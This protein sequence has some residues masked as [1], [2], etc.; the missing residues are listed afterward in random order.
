MA[1]A[2][3]TIGDGGR[4]FEADATQHAATLTTPGGIVSNRGTDANGSGK[5]FINP[6]GGDVDTSQPATVPCIPLP[7][8]S[9]YRLPFTCK[10]FTFKASASTFLV[11]SKG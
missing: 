7:V 9:S 1:S 11:F 3:V 5:A 2:D 8:G 4:E 6:D 10:Y